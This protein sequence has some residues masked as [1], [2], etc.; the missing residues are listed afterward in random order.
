[1]RTR[2]A[3]EAKSSR[4][5]QN[6]READEERCQRYRLRQK[7][8]RREHNRV[9]SERC[10]QRGDERL[11]L[12]VAWGLLGRQTITQTSPTGNLPNTRS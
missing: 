4:G 8:R 2:G 6:E 1:M 5:R 7:Q 10:E 12:I 3:E 11:P 9:R